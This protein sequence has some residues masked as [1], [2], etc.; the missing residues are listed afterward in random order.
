MQNPKSTALPFFAYGLF[1]PGQLGFERLEP[2]VADCRMRCI[3]DGTL[4]LRDGIPL[5]ESGTGY[6]TSGALIYFRV[7]DSD[8]A[9]SR[10]SEIEPDDQ[11]YWGE[12]DITYHEG[13]RDVLESANVLVGKKPQRGS[14]GFQGSDWDGRDDPL[15]KEGLEVIEDTL[16][17][18]GDF[19]D[20][21]RK[22]FQLQM[23]YLLLWSAIERYAALRYHLGDEV[24]QKVRH[25][26]GESTFKEGVA[27][28]PDNGGLWV[29]SAK[30]PGTRVRFIPVNPKK[31]LDYYYQIR[32]NITHRG[33]AE[34]SDFY[35]VH[36]ALSELLPIFRKMLDEAF[37]PH[38]SWR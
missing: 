15:F 24:V 32:S 21:L 2:H 36:K 26:A 9:Y 34:R 12:I 25:I 5:F 13:H 31:S 37:K 11:Y 20:D 4:W 30:E 27:L 6:R 14:V 17:K 8:V 28:L 38:P 7:G 33:K 29:Y 18:N 23:A 16:N 19:H 3:A 35:R 22:L 10:V 1:K